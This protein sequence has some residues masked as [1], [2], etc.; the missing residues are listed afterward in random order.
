MCQSP[1]IAKRV[2]TQLNGVIR[3]MYSNPPRHG[4]EIVKFVLTD[5][6]NFASWEQECK[7]MSGRINE[8]RTALRKQLEDDKVKS[9][10]GTDWSHIT[11]QIG[12][13]SFTGL[14]VKQAQMCR[15]QESVYLLDSGRI[16]MAGLNQSNVK[17][18]A[19]AFK[20]VIDKY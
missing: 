5:P 19:N 12:M 3:P 2:Q 11:S 7:K 6:K 18:V 8:M 14:S 1:E 10:T 4:M 20:T 17:F 13:F 16:S 15:E 9:P